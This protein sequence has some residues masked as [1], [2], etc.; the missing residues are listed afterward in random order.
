MNDAPRRLLFACTRNAV[1]SPMAE[2]L[3]RL[4]LGSGT[5]IASAG[6][7]PG[8][9]NPFAIAVMDEIG[10]DIRNH[11]A[12]TFDELSGS[13]FDLVIALSAIAFREATAYAASRPMAVERWDV[14][15]PTLNEGSREQRLTAFRATRSDLEA[16][17][18]KRFPNT[19]G[20]G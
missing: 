1:R 10:V 7:E 2:A 18:R 6:V 14:A 19:S 9:V 20:L 11:L 4:W 5:F 8:A 16:R 13:S 3:A 12:V 17:I 15:D